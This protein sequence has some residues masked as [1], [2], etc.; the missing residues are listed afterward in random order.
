MVHEAKASSLTGTLLKMQT[1]EY[2]PGVLHIRISSGKALEAVFTNSL[3]DVD[4]SQV[5][6]ML[7]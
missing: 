5:C 4:T 3:V 2:Y 7:V 6:D 1:I